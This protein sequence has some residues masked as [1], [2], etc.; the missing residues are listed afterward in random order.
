MRDWV[1]C[2]V[3]PKAKN[4]IKLKFKAKNKI[5]LKFKAKQSKK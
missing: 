4:K 5:K 2:I 3:N 1:F